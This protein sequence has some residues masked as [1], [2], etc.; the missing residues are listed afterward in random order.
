MSAPSFRDVE[1]LSTYLDGQ[2]GRSESVRLE[3]RLESEP[4]LRAVLNDLR[5]SRGLLRRLPSRRAPRN[6]TL[7]PRMA[8]LR[9]PAPRAFGALRFATA[10]ATFLLVASVAV[11]ALA[12]LAAARQAYA[13]AYGMGGGGGGPADSGPSEGPPQP[14]AEL[15]P[16]ATADAARTL[17]SEE[18]SKA[19]GNAGGSRAASQASP[20]AASPVPAAWQTGL[21]AL[22][23]ILGMATW[24][25]YRSA[26]QK[27]RKKWRSSK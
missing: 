15:V 23:L 14:F 10:L 8:G 3:T 11:N 26:D 1:L 22:A 21:A 12:P 19:T 4:E 27:F 20:P 13:P 5:H 17:S 18:L 16:T 6:F 9:P 2:L 25:L 7:S 24:A